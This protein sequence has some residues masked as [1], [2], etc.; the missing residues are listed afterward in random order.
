MRLV[1]AR[2]GRSE[3]RFDAANPE[4]NL[5]LPDGSRLFATMEVSARP[6][7]VI[8][9][10]RFELSSLAE[11]ADRGMVDDARGRLP[12]RR[13]AGP[14]QPDHRRRHRHREDH[15]AARPAQRGAGG[16]SASSRSRTPTS[17]ASTASPTSTPT[18]TCCRPGRPTS[19]ARGEITMLDLTRMALRM[20][21]D[22]VDRR[23][24]PRRRGLP[25]AAGDEPGQQRLDVHDPR[26]RHAAPCS[27]SWRPTWRWPTRNLPVETVN[28]LRGHRRCTS[29]STSRWSTACA[30]WP[31]SA[32]SSTPTAPA[33]CR[34]RCSCPGRTGAA[35]PGYPLRDATLRAARGPRVRRRPAA[36]SRP[37]VGAMTALSSLGAR[38]RRR[39]RGAAGAGRRAGAERCPGPA[40]VAGVAQGG[41]RPA[42]CS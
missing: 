25:D 39:P 33:S 26:R 28:L 17:S 22:R 37:A 8:R 19:R 4:L 32:R 30:A 6:S 20:D 29:S 35:V 14:A 15:A 40:Q 10:H 21:P 41:R 24:G 11:L 42:T 12:G 13:R 31:A 5:Q 18:T 36:R 27:R 7:V 2:M 16:A 3:R 1:A 34:T 38:R 23:R 9:R